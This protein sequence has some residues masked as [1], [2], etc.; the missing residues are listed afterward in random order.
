MPMCKTGRIANRQSS[1]PNLTNLAVLEVIDM[2]KFGLV[3]PFFFFGLFFVFFLVI[4]SKLCIF[5]FGLALWHD[6]IS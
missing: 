1:T 5:G 3:V 4:S 6:S 2:G